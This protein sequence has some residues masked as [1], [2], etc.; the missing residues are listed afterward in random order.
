LWGGEGEADDE[1]DDERGE[2]PGV[3]RRLAPAFS[4]FLLGSTVSV[5]AFSSSS[6]SSSSS[7]SEYSSSCR[8]DAGT[9]PDAIARAQTPSQSHVSK[10]RSAAACVNVVKRCPS[11]PN[12]LSL[13]LSLQLET[14]WRRLRLARLARRRLRRPW[15]PSQ[16]PPTRSPKRCPQTRSTSCTCAAER[17]SVPVPVP[18]PA[19]ELWAV[20]GAGWRTTIWGWRGPR[21]WPPPSPSARPSSGSS[22][23]AR[24]PDPW[25]RP[26]L[27]HAP[28]PRVPRSLWNNQMGDEGF[29]LVAEKLL[30]TAATIKSIK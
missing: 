11:L 28:R 9:S 6:T 27:T 13:S 16:R 20:G 18:A 30:K 1:K 10:T 19:P 12:S 15:R 17:W 29:K 22:T 25:P 5:S 7:S 21:R 4:P 2:G 8:S 14:L 24:G 26:S 3:R 23:Q